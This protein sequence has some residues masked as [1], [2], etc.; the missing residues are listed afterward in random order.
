[1]RAKIVD[2]WRHVDSPRKAVGERAWMS[3]VRQSECEPALERA[4]VG[5]EFKLES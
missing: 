5:V 2:S 4:I 1:M 3:V